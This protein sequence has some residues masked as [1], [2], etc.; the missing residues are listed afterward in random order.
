MLDSISTA[1]SRMGILYLRSRVRR[2]D[3]LPR[4]AVGR[5]LDIV[6]GDRTCFSVREG[7]GVWSFFG[8][9]TLSS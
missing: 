6:I 7:T 1:L 8:D 9:Q 3:L 4:Q 2:D 5:Y